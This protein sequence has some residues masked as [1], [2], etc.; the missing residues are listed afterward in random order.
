MQKKHFIIILFLFANALLFAQSNNTEIAPPAFTMYKDNYFIF[1][2]TL[3]NKPDIQSSNVKYQVSF[4]YRITEPILPFKTALY[5]TYTQKSI[6]RILANSKP[7]AE[8]NYNPSLGIEK[9]LFYKNKRKGRFALYLEHES[10]GKDIPTSR[11]WNKITLHYQHYFNENMRLNTQIWLPFADYLDNPDLIDFV[12]YGDLS[13]H[14]QLP[15]QRLSF[16]IAA[17]KGGAWDWRGSLETQIGFQLS[18]KSNQYL[19]LQWFK[20]MG[21]TLIVYNR[22]LNM[23]RIGYCMKPDF[24]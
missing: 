1:G 19:M 16:D 4:K 10:N 5:L 6:W 21:E 9:T 23:L 2:A 13:F 15:K 18:K 12:G 24:F 22:P 7:F 20:G 11:S 3:N 8:S 14:A 17:R